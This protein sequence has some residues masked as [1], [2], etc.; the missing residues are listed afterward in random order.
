MRKLI[1]TIENILKGA[2]SLLDIMPRE[3]RV[4]FYF[5][6]KYLGVRKYN[7]RDPRSAWDDLGEDMR[8][9]IGDFNN[10]YRP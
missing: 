5:S 4:R 1:K 9:T 8:V 6:P 7:M 2:G 10:T 3:K